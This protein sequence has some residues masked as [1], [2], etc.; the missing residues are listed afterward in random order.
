MFRSF[1]VISS[2]YVG[3][4]DQNDDPIVEHRNLF[5][6]CPFMQGRNVGNIPISD[7]ELFT[8]GDEDETSS[9][10]GGGGGN[11]RANVSLESAGGVSESSLVEEEI[12]T[13]EVG[14]R[15]RTRNI[16]PTESEK[17]NSSFFPC[18]S[19]IYFGAN[20]IPAHDQIS[21]FKFRMIGY[22]NI[23]FLHGSS[24]NLF[25]KLT[26]RSCVISSCTTSLL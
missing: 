8:D 1:S 20:L 26:A 7:E 21:R 9:S 18:Y 25:R 17:G 13:D 2:E 23:I 3:E 14:L 5:S 15:P 24:L 6:H 10:V 4:W 19:S 22:M 12:G 11:T 16:N